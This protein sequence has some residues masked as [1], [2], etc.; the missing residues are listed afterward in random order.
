MNFVNRAWKYVSRG[1]SK[2][3]LLGLTFFIVGNLI[4]ICL[5]VM[6]AS[7]NAKDIVRQ[8]MYP[9]VDYEI[10]YDAFWEDN[11]D[12]PEDLYSPVIGIEEVKEIAEDERVRAVN[13][14]TTYSAGLVSLQYVPVG[15]EDL[16]AENGG[17]T[18]ISY[19]STGE[20]VEI[21]Q[22]ATN[23]FLSGNTMANLIEFDNG[24]Y[25]ISSGRMY[26]DAE[27]ENYDAV[28][29]ITKELAELNGLSVGDTF[30]I[31]ID[32][33]TTLTVENGITQEDLYK[34]FEII[35]I[36]ETIEKVDPASENF[37]WLSPYESP[38][39]RILVPA[40][41]LAKTSYDYNTVA[42]AQWYPDETFGE[43][44]INAYLSGRA[45]FL[46]NN[47]EEVDSFIADYEHKLDDY[48]FFNAN[49]EEF[50]EISK[51]LNSLSSTVT[52]VFWIVV[53][54][55]IVIVSLVI[56]LTLKTRESEI[57][58]LLST[59][60]SKVKVMAQLFLEMLIVTV[61]GFT[62]AVFSGMLLAG[63]A[64]EMI[65]ANQLTREETTIEDDYYYESIWDQDYFTEI[66][67]EELL[68]QYKV[69]VSTLTIMQIYGVG[70]V[71]VFISILVPGFMVMRLNPKQILLN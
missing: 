31:N 59:G 38:Q 55:S 23:V 64:G 46:L 19:D 16:Q 9:V 69:S 57:G 27:I 63:K 7:N 14:G 20:A 44:D 41:T 51:P 70:I 12:N 26:T 6:E 42:W 34:E 48:Q 56:A 52:I 61:V 10:D 47:P 24:T 49:Q 65:L 30:Q 11:V 71:V 25:T 17:S 45:T 3:I 67:Q 36:Y 15:N 18:T 33:W 53:L 28:A 58:I 40:T 1:I 5:G 54:N 35:G 2:S 66:S 4:I 68:A 62:L 37:A 39:N 29:L 43:F 8:S 22:N 60:A 32:P 50:E 13:F 21:D